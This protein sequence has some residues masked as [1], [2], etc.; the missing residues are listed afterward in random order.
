MCR[1]LTR[2]S[3]LAAS[4]LSS[5]QIESLKGTG[6]N[7]ML[8]KGDV[9]KALGKISSAWGTAE[10]LSTDKLGASGR[11]ASEVCPIFPL[12]HPSQLLQCGHSSHLG[13]HC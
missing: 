10:K 12:F 13:V 11:R 7:G 3:R 6:K 4:D 1:V 8:T 2:I 5:E 9:L